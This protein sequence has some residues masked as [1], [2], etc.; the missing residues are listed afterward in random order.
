MHAFIK[1]LVLELA[2]RIASNLGPFSVTGIV[3]WQLVAFLFQMTFM[4]LLGLI[5]VMAIAFGVFGSILSSAPT[6]VRPFAGLAF[7]CLVFSVPFTGII[8]LAGNMD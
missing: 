5:W 1:H 2:L 4:K 3:L 7:W 8:W 6:M